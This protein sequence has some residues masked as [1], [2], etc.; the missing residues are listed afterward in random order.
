MT[1][2]GLFHTQEQCLLFTKCQRFSWYEKPPPPV[3]RFWKGCLAIAGIRPA[4]YHHYLFYSSGFRRNEVKRKNNV[5][6]TKHINLKLG[7]FCRFSYYSSEIRTFLTYLPHRCSPSSANTVCLSTV[8]K[9][10]STHNSSPLTVDRCPS[11]WILRGYYLSS[12]KFRLSESHSNRS[13]KPIACQ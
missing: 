8:Q 11:L 13:R 3:P 7:Y 9:M 2:Y 6:G 1:L 12:K 5:Y 10:S 4:A